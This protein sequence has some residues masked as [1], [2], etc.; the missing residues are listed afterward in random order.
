M[1]NELQKQEQTKA[2]TPVQRLK[3]TIAMPSVQEQFKNALADNA[4]LFTA[5]L[6]ELY[7][8]DQYLQN[9]EPNDVIVEALKAASLK[10]PLN[11][12]LGFA[13]I[14][15]RRNG[16]GKWMPGMQIGWRGWVQLAQRSGQYMYINVDMI[17]EGEEVSS[18]R[19]SGALTITGKPTSNKVI[20][21]FGY[22]Q[23]LNGFK[24]AMY[25][26]IEKVIA[27]RNKYVPKWNKP[28]NAWS[29][30]FD[31]MALK[32]VISTLIRKWGV[33]SVEMLSAAAEEKT[34]EDY[35]REERAEFANG[36]VIEEPKSEKK[37]VSKGQTNLM[38]PG[39]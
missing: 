12:G 22:I 21:Y 19:M 31:E 28:G 13:W 35:A 17:F 5:N 9:C 25:W 16:D 27:H 4:P 2:L 1:A 37:P 10:L 3:K 32:T 30:S 14:V 33:L 34:E 39:Y 24:K 20:G 11:K 38:D 26:P 8:G 6:V 29:T 7:S 18:D 36:T 23:L 15:P